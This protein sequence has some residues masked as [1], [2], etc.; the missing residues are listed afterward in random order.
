MD[1]EDNRFEKSLNG[2]IVKFRAE[3]A[4]DRAKVYVAARASLKRA[5][6]SKP[7]DAKALELA[8]EKVESSFAE[9]RQTIAQRSSRAGT[10]AAMT[11][12]L[13]VSAGAAAIAYW[14][15]QAAGSAEGPAQQF[16]K[17]YNAGVPRLRDANAFLQQVVD[18]VIDRQKRDRSAF[19]ASAKAFIPLAKFD[20]QLASRMPKTLPGGTAVIVRADAFNFKILMNWTLCGVAS[21]SNP[22]MI[23]PVRSPGNTIGCP[24]FGL[25]STGAA[26]W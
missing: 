14:P 19:A 6:Y 25:W 11:F 16:V 18:S 22:D 5:Q 26:K 17:S 8:I 2:A 3:T 24:Y 10:L 23:D 13:G 12:V 1:L 20:Q 15:E 7:G 9:S 4:A 21:I